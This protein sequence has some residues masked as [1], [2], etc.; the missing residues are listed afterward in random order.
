MQAAHR[1]MRRVTSEKEFRPLAGVDHHR[2]QALDADNR[3][4]AMASLSYSL[5]CNCTVAHGLPPGQSIK[6]LGQGLGLTYSHVRL[7][8]TNKHWQGSFDKAA[9]AKTIVNQNAIHK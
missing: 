4:A 9:L 6:L 2:L 5:P 3:C 8:M 1:V 7:A